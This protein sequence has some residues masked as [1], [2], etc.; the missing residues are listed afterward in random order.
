MNHIDDKYIFDQERTHG[1][2]DPNF[3]RQM[4]SLGNINLSN[5]KCVIYKF[6]IVTDIIYH[7]VRFSEILH[8]TQYMTMNKK[9]PTKDIIKSYKQ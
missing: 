7:H 3:W 9:E 5:G 2:V 4:M 8:Q 1:D 6:L